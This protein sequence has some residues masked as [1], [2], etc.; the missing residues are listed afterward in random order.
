MLAG[1]KSREQELRQRLE[2]AYTEG[3]PDAAPILSCYLL[4]TCADDDED[5]K[6]KALELMRRAGETNTV[7]CLLLRMELE[8]D[9]EVKTKLFEQVLNSLRY[10]HSCIPRADELPLRIEVTRNKTSTAYYIRT[11]DEAQALIEQRRLGE[12]M[13]TTTLPVIHITNTSSD[14]LEKIHLRIVQEGMCGETSIDANEEMKPGEAYSIDL[15][16]YA[17]NNGNNIRMEMSVADGRYT[18]FTLPL[19]FIEATETQVPQ[20]QLYHSPDNLIILPINQD[21]E[22]LVLIAPSG[23][24]ITELS[25]LRKDEPVT[26]DIWHLKSV[27]LKERT[28]SFIMLCTDADPA[29]CF[30]K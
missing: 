2:Q 15:N 10:G 28:E 18:T 19:A 4:H 30:L 5:T 24:K 9:T 23:E 11:V 6:S 12:L 22:R 26:V 14:P 17:V 1:D 21:L 3:I 25:N 16:E 8:E 13:H 27:M 7:Q 20:V 29:I